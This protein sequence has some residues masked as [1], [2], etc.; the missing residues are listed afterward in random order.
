[1]YA[2]LYAIV[3]MVVLAAAGV[4]LAAGL[5]TPVV[6]VV[7]GFIAFGLVFMGMMSVLPA[8]VGHNAPHAEAKAN[9]GPAIGAVVDST[10]TKLRKI[11]AGLTAS[12]ATEIRKAKFH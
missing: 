2:K 6:G 7:F 12:T 3:W 1:M 9:V 8:T 5:M 11:G 4:F 10:A